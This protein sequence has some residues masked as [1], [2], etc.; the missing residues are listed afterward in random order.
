MCA[1]SSHTHTSV[2]PSAGKRTKEEEENLV[3]SHVPVLG[4]DSRA[5]GGRGR[6]A[7]LKNYSGRVTLRGYPLVVQGLDSML[8]LKVMGLSPVGGL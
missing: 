3:K 6:A 8:P 7:K 5:P 2:R 1:A 4:S